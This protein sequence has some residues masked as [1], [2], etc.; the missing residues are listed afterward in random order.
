VFLGDGITSPTFGGLSGESGELGIIFNYGNVIDL[1]LNPSADSVV[2]YGGDIPDGATGMSL[3]KTGAGTQI[4]SGA[5]TYT[6]TTTVS[7]GTLVFSNLTFAATI[8]SNSTTINF[9]NSPA[10]GTT[11]NILSGPLGTASLASYSVT[12]LS[13]NTVGTLTNNPNLQVIVTTAVPTGPTFE[14][15]YGSDPLAINPA[16]GLSNLMNYALGGTEPSSTPA[17]P[18][19]TSDGTSLT[20]TANIREAG[21]GVGVVGEY[22]YSLDGPWNEVVLTPTATPSTVPN[23]IVKAFSQAIEPGQPKKFL[24]LKATLTP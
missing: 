19:L 6:G 5:N 7:G 10:V 8:S 4:L 12:G 20:L 23:T 16:N 1:R 18:V 11:N 21:Q 13:S 22:A 15:T 3:T 14:G 17:L 2:T 24:R 9:A